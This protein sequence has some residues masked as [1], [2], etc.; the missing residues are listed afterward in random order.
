MDATT[1]RAPTY[2]DFARYIRAV[3]HVQELLERTTRAL[4]AAK[5]DYAVIGGNAVAAWVATI[6]P[7]AVRT[8]KDVDL[9]IRRAD[10]DK[11]AHALRPVGLV[12]TEVFGVSMFVEVTNPSPRRAVHLLFADEII[13]PHDPA[14]APRIENARPCALGFRVIPLLDLVQMKL[15]AFRLRDQTHLVDMLALGL[16]DA[17]WKDR[18]PPALQPKYQQ[19]LEQFEREERR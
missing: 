6:D 16:L 9:L 11:I 3:K 18:L 10:F 19:V 1:T 14:R 5:L 4:D 7:D 2:E 15:L 8:T 13:S 12:P 17:S